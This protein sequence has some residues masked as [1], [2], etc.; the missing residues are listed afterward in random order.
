MF[1]LA[2][3]GTSPVTVTSVKVPPPPG[4]A[5]TVAWLMPPY[6]PPHGSL[7]FVGD[8]MTYPPTSWPT[9]LDRQAMPG[10]V[11]K[12]HQTLNLFFGIARTAARRVEA[13]AP[14]ITY[15]SGRN[16]YTLQ[17]HWAYILLAPH[18]HCPRT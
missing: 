16:T 8:G 1:I 10:A 6:K 14:I 12:P 11:V 15:T 18:T 7:S 9:W 2:N 4:V 13:G 17:T 3:T 5:V